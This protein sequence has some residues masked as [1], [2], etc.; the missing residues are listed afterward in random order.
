MNTKTKI[1]TTTKMT[2]MANNH[3]PLH[4]YASMQAY[5]DVCCFTT[6][7]HGGCSTGE[8]ASFNCNAYC[9]DDD[10]AVHRNRELL[11]SLLPQQPD[12][13]IIPHQ[14]HG[15][16]IRLINEDFV[17]CSAF[18]R[19]ALLEGVDALVTHLPGQCICVSTADCIPVIC[20]DRR[21]HIAAVIHAGW[22]GTAA[23]IVGKTL[24]VMKQA[25]GSHA[26]DIAACLGPG[27]SIGAFEV[28]DEVYGAF[29]DAGFD[30]ERI[31]RQEYE[32]WHIDLWEANRL[33]LMAEG[34][35]EA[36]IEVSGICTY[37]HNDDFFSARR[38]G[39]DSGR[40]LTGILML[41]T[42]Q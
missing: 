7:R 21:L 20:Y 5:T 32:R 15:T 31:A 34:V 19:Q 24:H 14:T 40:M 38:Q 9:G 1:G 27:I 26:E 10:G 41:H 13:L 29:A 37:A 30:M 25:Y 35:P 6:T 22:R 42:P 36:Q 4:A 12:G 17:R 33:L 39:I 18:T 3:S 28:G 8:Y 23:R 2:K 16:E 11:C